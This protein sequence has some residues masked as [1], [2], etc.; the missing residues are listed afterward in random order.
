MRVCSSLL[1]LAA[2]VTLVSC[3]G[4]SSSSTPGAPNSTSTTVTVLAPSGNPVSQIPVT[5]STG[6]A[7][8]TPTGV[9]S[10]KNTSGNGA[11]TFS[12]L[13]SQGQ[14]CVSTTNGVS[15]VNHCQQPF[16]STVTLQFAPS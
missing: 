16:P 15:S 7:G 2:C 14:L 9:I 13:P 12:S 8:T 3:G 5:L 1:V 10:I 11:V 4:G 6:V